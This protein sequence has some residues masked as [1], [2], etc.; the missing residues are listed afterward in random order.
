[1]KGSFEIKRL[2]PNK[3]YY[4]SSKDYDSRLGGEFRLFIHPFSI[5]DSNAF[6]YVRRLMDGQMQIEGEGY[7]VTSKDSLNRHKADARRTFSGNRIWYYWLD[8][9]CN[10][11]QKEVI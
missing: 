1:M 5:D 7:I 4:I 11:I 9:A 6:Y 10:V 8:E 3:P 2:H